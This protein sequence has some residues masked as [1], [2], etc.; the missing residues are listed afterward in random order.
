MRPEKLF[1]VGI[2]GLIVSNGKYL[3]LKA[4]TRNHLEK[5]EPYWDIPGGRIEEGASAEET[6]KREV[7]EE[8]GISLVT[9]IRFFTAVI[10]KHEIPLDSGRKAGLVLMVYEAQIPAGSTIKLS[11]EHT[12]YD[13]TDPKEAADRLSNK[14]PEHFTNSLKAK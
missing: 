13:W 5:T 8:T 12:E 4:S 7:E 14:Y 1:Y 3:L 9:G 10:S 11:P 2:K 6:L